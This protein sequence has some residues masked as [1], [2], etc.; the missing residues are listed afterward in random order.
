[1]RKISSISSRERR[2]VSAGDVRKHRNN[3]NRI[4]RALT[5]VEEVDTR[6]DKGVDDGEND[7]G[8]VSDGLES[9]RSNHNDH[10]EVKLVHMY[11]RKI[12]DELTS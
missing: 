7:I 5:R 12:K 4:K 2:R 8:L 3:N 9:D 10:A 1:L 6:D 11:N